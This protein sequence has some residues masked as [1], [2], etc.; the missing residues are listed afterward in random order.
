MINRYEYEG[1]VWIDLENPTSD[2]I[3]DIGQ[4]FNLGHLLRTEL[5]APTLK[6]RVDLYPESVYTLLHFPAGRHTKG[7]RATQE[8][9]FVIGKQFII[10]VHYDTVDA[11]VDFARSFEAAMLLNRQNGKL[12]SGYILFEL[13]QRLYQEVEYELDVI[14][15]T[16]T[17][18]EN[19]IFSGHE[20]DMVVS[21]SRITRELI[22]QKRDLSLHAEV[23]TSLER[24]TVSLFGPN[25]AHYIHGVSAF[26]YRAYQRALSLM[27]T[28]TEI[29]KTNDSL[30]TASQNEITK[31]LTI[32]AFI[33][34]PLSLIAAIFGMN[35]TYTPVVNSPHG[36]WFITGAMFILMS[37]FF[38]YFKIKRW[39]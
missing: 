2:E 37:S 4:E 8:V 28:I 25:F 6:P 1:V 7:I 27:D 30:L 12:H 10:T 29:R 14:E 23:L 36:F 16:M 31:N 38:I 34:F 39:F 18:I 35:T 33:T 11:L 22:D 26:H 5:L 21:I 20:K 3:A 24:A 9:D 15:D 17:N 32:M 13:A 19:S